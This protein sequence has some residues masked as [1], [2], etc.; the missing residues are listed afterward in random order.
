MSRSGHPHVH[1]DYLARVRYSNALPPP[2][3]YPKFLDI[4]NTG[5]SSGLYTSPHY[6]SRLAREQPLNIEADAELGMPIDLVGIQG[7]FEGKEEKIMFDEDPAPLHPKDRELLRPLNALGKPVASTNAVSFLRRTEYLSGKSMVNKAANN[8]LMGGRNAKQNNKSKTTNKDDP[9]SILRG[10]VKGFNIANPQDAYTGE[11]DQKN[12][13]GAPI[14]EAERQAWKNP[15]HPTKSGLK[16]L[17]SYPILPDLDAF[18]DT[19]NYVLLKY[20]TNPSDIS[21]HYDPRLDV[22]L[23]RPI[24]HTADEEAAF[25]EKVALAKTDPSRPA[26]LPEFRYDVLIPENS[27]SV[28]AIKRKFDVADASNDSPD[29]YDYENP[30]THRPAFRYKRLRQYETYLQAGNADDAWNDSVALMLN[31]GEAGSRLKKG[32]YLYPIVQRT[33]IRPVRPKGKMGNLAR[34]AMAGEEEGED[35]I[36]KMEVCVRGLNENE[37]ERIADYREKY[38]KVPAGED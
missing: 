3:F 15:K 4:P 31:D 27:D 24:T 7:V 23:V 8:A 10:I 30:E 2:P 20:Q 25:E 14:T 37:V 32:A 9:I 22:A 19:G 28:P 26:P 12:L 38:D 21:T 34:G 29:L 5:L 13:V 18:P 35:V 33:S 6:A 17:D 16:L 11:D 36:H 1:Q